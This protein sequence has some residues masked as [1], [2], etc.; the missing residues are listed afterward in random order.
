MHRELRHNAGTI[1]GVVDAAE[2]SLRRRMRAGLQ[3]SLSEAAARNGEAIHFAV[4]RL[5]LLLSKPLIEQ[6][7]RTLTPR[8]HLSGVHSALSFSNGLGLVKK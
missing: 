4:G 1:E 2:D 7:N 3:R 5:V 8:Q 6:Q